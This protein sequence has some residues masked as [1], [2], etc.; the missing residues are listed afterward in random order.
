MK[1]KLVNE[2]AEVPKRAT[3]GSAGYDLYSAED[4]IL[5][6]GTRKLVSTGV[7]MEIPDGYYGQVLPRSGLALRSGL[8]TMAGVIDSDYRS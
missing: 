5:L 8:M 3:D 2:S 1:V 4:K 7:T 6:P